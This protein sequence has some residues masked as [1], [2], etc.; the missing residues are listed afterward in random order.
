MIAFNFKH[1]CLESYAVNMPPIE[2]TSSAIEDRL[3]P[4]YQRLQIPFGTLEKLSGIYSRYL[5]E[6]TTLPSE[7]ATVAARQALQKSGI[8]A[9]QIG[10]LFSCSVTRDNF[11]PATACIIHRNLEL[12]E[13]SVAFDISNACIGFSDGL[14]VLGNMIESGVVKAGIVVSGENVARIV[15]NSFKALLQDESLSRE[16]LIQLLPTLTLGSGAVAFVLCHDSIS[17]RKH[18]FLGGALR[19]ATEHKDLCSGNADSCAHD[20]NNQFVLMRTESSKIVAA[21]SKLGSRVWPEASQVL[22][23]KREDVQHIFCHQIGRQVNEAFYR[24][25][26]LDFEKEYTIYKKYGNL[27]S[28]ALPVALALGVEEKPVRK[29]E[30]VLCTAFGSGL[31]AVFYGFEW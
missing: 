23:W 13:Q 4:L 15:E 6:T 10:A 17:T 18:R 30:K 14:M 11:E 31:N 21:A 2:L 1:V 22:G 28:A 8:A 24:E 26:G 19:S 5:W 27:V 25:M 9:D 29:G 12:G 20:V 3:A 16:D 7:V